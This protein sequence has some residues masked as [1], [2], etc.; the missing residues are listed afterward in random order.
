MCWITSSVVWL[1]GKVV[2]WVLLDILVHV[3]LGSWFFEVEG[4]GVGKIE[5]LILRLGCE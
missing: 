4:V 5:D 2:R 3:P 1:P